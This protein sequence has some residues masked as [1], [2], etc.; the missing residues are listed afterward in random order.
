MSSDHF[1]DERAIH[2]A[3]DESVV[4]ADALLGMA[5]L[6]ESQPARE[7]ITLSRCWTPAA[8]TYTYH[9][10]VQVH[11]V[12]RNI[13]SKVVDCFYYASTL[14]TQPWYAAFLRGCCVPLSPATG[15]ARALLCVPE[16]DFGLGKVHSYR[17]LL[18]D[19]SVAEHCHVLVLRSVIHALDFPANTV[20][21]FTLA[22]TGD[23]FHWQG[24]VLHWHHICTV[25]GVGILPACIERHVMNALRWFH[26]DQAERKA[27]REEAES[28]ICWVRN[29]EH[30]TATW[31]TISAA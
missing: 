7:A 15:S 9:T 12:D 4:V 31:E 3:S 13:F 11:G 6:A 24:G 22:P 16:F 8:R 28:F 19:F 30:V 23:V 21:A 25:A 10:H 18:N 29:V 2:D 27:Y 20:P 17:Q 26:L 1:P 14:P 5:R